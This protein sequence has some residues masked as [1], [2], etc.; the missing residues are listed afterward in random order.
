MWLAWRPTALAV[1]PNGKAW[2]CRLH[3]GGRANNKRERV[4]VCGEF[5]LHG[6]FGDKREREGGSGRLRDKQA[7]EVSFRSER[8]L[9]NVPRHLTRCTS[10]QLFRMECTKC[11]KLR[12]DRPVMNWKARQTIQN[13]PEDDNAK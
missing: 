13:N 7:P 12:A 4:Y 11:R 5:L 9:C 3:E 6:Y 10:A 1:A 8:A 2:L